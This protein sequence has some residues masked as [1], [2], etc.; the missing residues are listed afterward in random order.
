MKRLNQVFVIFGMMVLLSVSSFANEKD[1]TDLVNEYI[2]GVKEKE[3]KS[4]DKLINDDANFIKIN[5]IINKKNVNDKDEFLK[6]VK[7][8]HFCSSAT[9]TNVKIVEYEDA[10]AIACVDYE[11]NRIVVKEF[12]TLVLSEGKW[13]VVN[14]VCSLKK[15]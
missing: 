6:V 15:T 2:R 11:G 9:E 10:M 14:S 3:V 7:A 5:T 12:L 8:G 4:V 13:E 1:V